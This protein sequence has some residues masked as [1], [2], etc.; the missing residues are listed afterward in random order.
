MI[1]LSNHLFSHWSR[2]L[3]PAMGTRNQVGIGLS[4]RP[5]SPSSL[6]T[7]FQ[8]RFLESIPRPIAGLKFSPLYSVLCTPLYPVLCPLSLHESK[9]RVQLWTLSWKLKSRYGAR[10]RFQ[11]PTL[12]LSSQATLAGQYVNPIPTWFLAPIVGLK[13]PTL[14]SLLKGTQ[15]WDNFEFYFYLNQILICPL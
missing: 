5:A 12:K 3:S 4:Y 10:N 1:P 6:A 15:A 14:V 7:Q 2:P 11:E 8:T 13:L 9:W